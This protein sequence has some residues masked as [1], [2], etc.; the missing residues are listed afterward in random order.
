MNKMILAAALTLAATLPFSSTSAFAET[1][2]APTA[3]CAEAPAKAE[4]AGIDCATTSAFEPDRTEKSD[5]YPAGPV[6][7]GNGIVF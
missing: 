4:K 5:Q 7:S 2:H 6:Y 3:L 1:T